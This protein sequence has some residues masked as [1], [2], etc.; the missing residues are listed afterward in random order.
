VTCGIQI[1][2]IYTKVVLRLFSF[3][4][5]PNVAILHLFCATISREDFFKKITIENQLITS[6]V[7]TY[8]FWR[9][10]PHAVIL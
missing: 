6:T 4:L 2:D 9:A 5:V 7:M 8:Y 3:L 10:A 1:I